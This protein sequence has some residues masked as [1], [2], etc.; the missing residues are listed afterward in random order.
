M[1]MTH[2]QALGSFVVADRVRLDSILDSMARRLH[3][4][5]GR[6]VSLVGIR[7]RGAPL[8]EELARRFARLSGAPPATG[9]IELSRYTDDLGLL[10][11]RPLSGAI[12]LPPGIGDGTVVLVDDV[13]YTGRTLLHAIEVLLGHG[14]RRVA[15]AVLCSRGATEI[16]IEAGVVGMRFDLGEG[17]I[18]EVRIPPYESEMTVALRHAPDR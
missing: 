14:A 7:R 9:E 2:G 12:E 3:A 8:A 6:E 4:G 18:I 15:V 1:G 13:L 17:D 11:D 5:M 10:H 16:P